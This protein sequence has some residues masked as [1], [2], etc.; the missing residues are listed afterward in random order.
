MCSRQLQCHAPEFIRY[1]ESGIEEVVLGFQISF[2]LLHKDEM[3]Q[4]YRFKAIARV[5]NFAR[6]DFIFN[7]ETFKINETIIF[8]W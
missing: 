8:G 5:I 2:R 7:E 6:P 4:F 1:R 3:S